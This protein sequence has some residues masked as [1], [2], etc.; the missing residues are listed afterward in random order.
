[1]VA[2]HPDPTG[3][4][5]PLTAKEAALVRQLQAQA[6]LEDLD[7][8]PDSYV[9]ALPAVERL[10]ALRGAL[11]DLGEAATDGRQGLG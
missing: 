8:G 6:P 3:G 10:A 7:L 11:E 5:R 1:M 2:S 4:Q 9:W